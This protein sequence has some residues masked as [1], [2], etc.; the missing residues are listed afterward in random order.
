MRDSLAFILMGVLILIL[1]V[2]II[3]FRRYGMKSKLG[4]FAVGL[5]LVM[6]FIIMV[7]SAF[8]TPM[9]MDEYVFYRLS[10]GLPNYSTTSDWFYKDRPDL[11]N[12]SVTWEDKSSVVIDKRASFDWI[13][14]NP[15]YLHDPLA[16]ALVYPIVKT[17][18][19]MA[20]K[21][22][23]QHIED[24]PGYPLISKTVPQ[25]E[26]DAILKD[27]KA[28]TITKVLRVLSICIFILSMYLA[29][30][31]MFKKVGKKVLFFAVPIAVGMQLLTG[32]YLF[33]WDIFMLF[34]FVLTLYLMES[35][36]P[37]WAFLTACCMVNTKMFIGILFLIPLII[38]NRKMF[39]A[40]FSIIPFYLVIAFGTHDLFYPF[41]HYFTGLGIG[42]HNYVYTLYDNWGWFWLIVDLGTPVFLLMTVPL[43]WR[44]KKYPE[45]IALWICAMVYAW[46]SGLGITH[47]SCML[48]VGVLIFPLVVYEFNLY[49]RLVKFLQSVN[50]PMEK[51]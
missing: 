34:F 3:I 24:Q 40:A 10:S 11:L 44:L 48:Y 49:E 1:V 27:M 32:V 21:G 5:P 39:W 41:R 37:N 30:K 16:P 46:G 47:L 45:Y 4:L 28:E 2:S 19:V 29:Y 9:W 23:I 6:F 31:I 14:N 42:T 26:K 22:I 13:Y 12:P 25:T 7:M 36:H 43:F 18:N 33:Y 51:V 15:V 17:L 35:N 50:P 20:D 8:R 38:K